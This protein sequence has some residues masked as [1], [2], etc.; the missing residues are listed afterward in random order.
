MLTLGKKTSN[1]QSLLR[2]YDKAFECFSEAVK[3]DP[4][5]VNIKIL[6]TI[7]DNEGLALS[8]RN[9]YLNETEKKDAL[10]LYSSLVKAQSM[11][12]AGIKKAGEIL[13][14]MEKVINNCKTARIDYISIVNPETLAAVP[15]V[16]KGDVVALA[17][18]IG[19]T[20]L[21]DNVIL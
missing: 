5:D 7:R 17:V 4:L 11:V 19:K 10:C 2:E 15:R 9:A 13:L 6:P 12:N 21:I 3:S 16:R 1:K 14:E 18:R 8:S 20:R